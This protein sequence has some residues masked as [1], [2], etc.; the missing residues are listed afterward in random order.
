MPGK[1]DLGAWPEGPSGLSPS[2][3]S[4]LCNPR[5]AQGLSG[6]RDWSWGEATE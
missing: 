6:K 2:S 4:V 1:G 3:M 5:N